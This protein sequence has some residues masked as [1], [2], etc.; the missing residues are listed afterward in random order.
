MSESKCNIQKV[1]AE[2]VARKYPSFN[3]AGSKLLIS[4]KEIFWEVTWALPAGTLGGVPIL[5]IDKRTCAV[6]RTQHSQ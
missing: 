3:A 1:A 6:V 5:H 2:F 4:E